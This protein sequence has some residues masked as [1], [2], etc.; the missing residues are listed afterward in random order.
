[1]AVDGN[2]SNPIVLEHFM[3]RGKPCLALHFTYDKA[4]MVCAKKAGAT[5]SQTRKTW[6]VPNEANALDKVF[7]AFKGIAWV[8]IKALR[9]THSPTKSAPPAQTL[10]KKGP[11]PIALPKGYMETLVRRRYGTSTQKQYISHFRAFLAHFDK[12]DPAHIN[13]EEIKDY[14]LHL[15]RIKKVSPSTQNGAINAIKFY[16]EK[17]LGQQ[18]REYW[19]DRP[20]KEKR[21]PTVASEAE[22]LRLIAATENAKH[23]AIISMLYSTG[24]RR[25]ELLNLRIKDVNMDRAQV[26][27]RGGKGKKDRYT[28]LSLKLAKVL[29][30]YVHEHAPNYWF[31]EGPNR[32]QYSGSSVGAII[33]RSCLNAGIKTHITPHVLRHSFATHLMERGVDLRS[34]QKLL[35]HSSLKTTETCLPAGRSTHMLVTFLCKRSPT[36]L[37]LFLKITN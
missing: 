33:K 9:Q 12:K 32:S 13:E 30:A 19:I 6:Y 5:W 29:V 36:H 8:D 24:I 1:M 35:G 18:K 37:M 17:V 15:V 28:T 31:F 21:L 2:T 7:K 26:F 16:Y 14:L 20:R 27:V 25:A 23:K 22:V 11:T 34:I 10:T 4:L 3:H